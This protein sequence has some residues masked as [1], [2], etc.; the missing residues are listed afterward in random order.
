MRLNKVSAGFTMIELMITLS[1]FAIVLAVAVPSFR[2][3]I[4]DNRVSSQA[5]LLL[6]AMKA[7]R[8]EA[9]RSGVPISL[10]RN[11]GSFA[12]GWCIRHGALG[13]GC[14]D[15]DAPPV[16]AQLPAGPDLVR[17]FDEP[18]AMTINEGAI[19]AGITY[20]PRGLMTAPAGAITIDMQPENCV[21]GEPRRRVIRVSAAGRPSLVTQPCI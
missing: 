3:L 6:G 7:A 15:P 4:E 16:D 13:G 20:G 14:P 5:N 10:E 1:V 9:V 2:T 19:A 12:N 8:S 11:N 21:A 18:G 17:F